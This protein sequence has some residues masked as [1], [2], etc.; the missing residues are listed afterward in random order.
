MPILD[1]PAVKVSQ[2]STSAGNLANAI[3]LLRWKKAKSLRQ[4]F[5]ELCKVH[6]KSF[7]VPVTAFDRWQARSKQH[8]RK[9]VIGEDTLCDPYFPSDSEFADP[10][11]VRDLKRHKMPVSAAEK[12]SAALSKHSTKAAMQMVLATSDP[13]EQ[14]EESVVS[15]SNREQTL[16]FSLGDAPKPF[17]SLNQGHYEKLQKLFKP[18][19][20]KDGGF[21]D[22]V[23]RLLCR[24][25]LLGGHG[26]QAALSEHGFSVLASKLGV[27]MECFASPLNCHFPQ[28]CS[29]FADTD[30][31]FGSSGTFFDFY[32]TEGSFEANPPFVPEVMSE[33]VKHMESLLRAAPGALSFAVIVPSWP[34]V[35]AWKRLQKSK[36]RYAG[37]TVAAADHG[38]CNGAQHESRDRY[39]PSSFATE[40]I[41]LQNEAGAARWPVTADIETEIRNA[42]SQ[43]LP[44]DMPTYK[45]WEQRG[46]SRG[47]K[48]QAGG[49]WNGNKKQK[50]TWES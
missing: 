14:S 1:L 39:R 28:Y 41:F 33:M 30:Q 2:T 48:K 38:F 44:A 43:A 23:Y 5:R 29:A 11:V 37:F 8:E 10:G 35:V 47:G 46:A 20:V 13:S 49:E 40:M 4:K 42:F 17:F 50:R 16:N 22:A 21:D 12:V 3:E 25:S 24:Y 36:W 15:V 32:P 31:P 34:E 45:Q 7:K 9:R 27:Q 6:D 19:H 18:E 26:S